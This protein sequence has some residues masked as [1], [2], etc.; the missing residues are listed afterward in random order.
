MYLPVAFAEHDPA[1]LWEMMAAW[2]FVTLVAGAD[3]PE[4]A[5][6]P[7][8]VHDR[9]LRGH[10]A[11]RN[12]LLS[13]AGERVT[14]VFNG[15][16][17]YIS[18]RWYVSGGQVPTWN[19]A[20]VHARGTLRTLER[21]GLV[22]VLAR[23]AATFE[24]GDRPWRMAEV[25]APHLQEMLDEIVGFELVDLELTGKLKLSQNRAPQDRAGVI[26]ALE[27][28]GTAEDREMLRWMRPGAGQEG[29]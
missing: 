9:T 2:P 27:A 16:H 24:E 5:H 3:E 8:L 13:R 6:A 11:R 17:G 7:L 25:E 29:S 22:H 12:P 4:I 1:R 21:A 14:A 28:R 18:P 26:A 15:P 19:Y 20:V 23:L 10:L